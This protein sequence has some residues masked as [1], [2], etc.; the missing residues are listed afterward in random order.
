MASEGREFDRLIAVI[1]KQQQ[2]INSIA[3]KLEKLESIG[4]GGG[5]ALLGLGGIL[6]RVFNKNITD[7]INN[8]VTRFQDLKANASALNAQQEV[9]NVLKANNLAANDKTTQQN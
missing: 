2:L 8:V 4:G 9:L 1:Q 7:E 5:T 6:G 3:D